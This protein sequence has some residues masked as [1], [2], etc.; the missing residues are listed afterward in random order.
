MGASGV[1][2]PHLTAAASPYWQARAGALGETA[3]GLADLD[4]SIRTI[5]ATPLGSVPLEPDFGCPILDHLDLPAPQA[6]PRIV[7]AVAAALA[8]WEQRIKVEAV[9]A[10]R[11]ADHALRLTVQWRPAD[12]SAAIQTT[13]VAWA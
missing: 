2:G 11:T 10:A 6:A 8:R 7:R 1:R 4:Q 13:E 9:D 12:A 5:L 3:E